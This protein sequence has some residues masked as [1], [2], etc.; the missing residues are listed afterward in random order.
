MDDP[1]TCVDELMRLAEW[2]RQNG[3]RIGAVKLG[4]LSLQIEDLRVDDKEG[5][6]PHEHQARGPW[7]DLG[8]PDGP[9]DDGT[10]GA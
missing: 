8:F 9:P 10:V 3:H 5:L 7:A 6:K 2:A 1:K 4:C